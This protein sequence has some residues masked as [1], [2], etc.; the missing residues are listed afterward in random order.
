MVSDGTATTAGAKAHA[1]EQEGTVVLTSPTRPA[2]DGL[3]W[4][5]V[6][7]G[8]NY[9]H[10]VLARGTEIT[11]TDLEGDACAN[12]LVYNADQPFERL[13]VA[14]TVK[15]QWQ[16]YAS[17]GYL[18]L[19]DQGRVLAS[20]I[21]DS[22]EHHD[23]IFGASTLG[24]NTKKYGDGTVH[25]ATP[26]GRELLTLA[27]SKNGLSRKDIAPSISFFK[28]VRV[29][30]DGSPVFL[31]SKGAGA[32]ITIKAEMPIILLIANTAHPLDGRPEFNSTP[33]EVAA[34]PGKATTST[35]ELWSKTPE[36]RRAFI[37]TQDYLAA[38]GIA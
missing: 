32:S 36:G 24:R 7:A 28:G 2:G 9:S 20:V 1:R 13:N 33:L 18:L 31:G 38:R 3:V 15:V 17:A 11:L 23:T 12:I 16:V 26:S 25:S 5:E 6:I 4:Q 10:K 37:N 34:K 29:Q 14:D 22:A 21:A 8:G 19:S 35:D 30:A 27:G